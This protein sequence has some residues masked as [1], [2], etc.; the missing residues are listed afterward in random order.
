MIY[1]QKECKVLGEEGCYFLSLLWV[2]E[3]ELGKDLDALAVF[4][5]AKRRGWVGDDCFVK[6]PAALVGHLLGKKCALRKSWS[7]AEKLADNERDIWCWRRDATGVTYW[8]FVAMDAAGNVAY[9][10]LENSNTVRLGKPES[11]RILSIG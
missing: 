7:F 4:D 5:E 11:R 2:A 3:R 10:P 1:K 8:H 6:D 9:D